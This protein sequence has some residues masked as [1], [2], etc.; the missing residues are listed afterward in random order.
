[1]RSKYQSHNKGKLELNEEGEKGNERSKQAKATSQQERIKTSHVIN[2]QINILIQWIETNIYYIPLCTPG[3]FTGDRG[4]KSPPTLGPGKHGQ[5]PSFSY[6]SLVE[7]IQK[8][9]WVPSSENNEYGLRIGPTLLKAQKLRTAQ[10]TFCAVYSNL[11]YLLIHG[12]SLWQLDDPKGLKMDCA[13]ARPLKQPSQRS[14][15][16]TRSSQHNFTNKEIL[17]YLFHAF[18]SFFSSSPPGCSC[19][20]QYL[21]V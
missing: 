17:K 14:F 10:T 11:F 18:S 15:I 7:S 16:I 20:C 6:R 1:M 19:Y 13:M 8:Q 5:S 21:P 12:R 2:Y 9:H 3:F 4:S